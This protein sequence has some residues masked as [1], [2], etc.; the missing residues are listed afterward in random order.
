[1]FL[2]QLVLHSLHLINPN[3][4]PKMAQ[5]GESFLQM[6]TPTEIMEYEEKRRFSWSVFFPYVELVYLPSTG[7][8]EVGNKKSNL[9]SKL[10]LMALETILF[11]LHNTLGRE[12]HREI[13]T[14]EK[15]LDYVICMPWNV[16]KTLQHKARMLISLLAPHIPIEPPRLSILAKAKL[17][18]TQFGLKKM[19]EIQSVNELTSQ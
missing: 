7:L 18:K 14:K 3:L 17:A 1:M 16:P 13:L 19:M 12:I 2:A 9:Q 5:Y 8:S 6:A 10:Q 4:L 11:W 15:L